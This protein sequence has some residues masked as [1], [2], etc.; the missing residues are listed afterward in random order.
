MSA[1]TFYPCADSAVHMNLRG[2]QHLEANR[3][4]EAITE[5]SRALTTVKTVLSQQ[6]SNGNLIMETD[7]Y[8]TKEP[9]LI[10]Q[11]AEPDDDDDD[12]E[13]EDSSSMKVDQQQE[14]GSPFIFKSAIVASFSCRA[15]PAQDQDDFHSL[16]K[17]SSSILFN[18][19]L[20]YHLAAMEHA[21]SN[22]QKMKR[23]LQKALTFYKLAY[24]MMQ[25]TKNNGVM[26]TMAIANNLGHVQLTVGDSDKARQCYEHLLSTIMFVADTGD[27]NSIPQ[28]DGFFHSVQAVV[29]P[30]GTTAQAA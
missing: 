4:L 12:D 26:E 22:E 1:T 18:L 16:V 27:R 5:F 19:A 10:F 25:D 28:F 17:F 13:D 21:S 30:F 9:R 11:F 6:D 14:E 7:E 23:L 24:T 3:F 20:S 15:S 2:V 8:A 29:L